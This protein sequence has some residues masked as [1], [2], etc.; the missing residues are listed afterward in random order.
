MSLSVSEKAG[1]LVGLTVQLPE[2]INFEFLFQASVKEEIN[3]LLTHF[4]GLPTQ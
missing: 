1:D 2:D 4:K 3:Q